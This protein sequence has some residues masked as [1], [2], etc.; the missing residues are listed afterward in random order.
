MATM[1]AHGLTDPDDELRLQD[2]VASGRRVWTLVR[3]RHQHLYLPVLV[4]AALGVLAGVVITPQYTAVMRLMP[5]RS[6]TD[7][8]ALLGMAG[9]GGMRLAADADAGAVRGELF[10]EVVASL[11]YQM[12]LAT[13]PLRFGIGDS[14][15]TFAAWIGA[16]PQT[17]T[18][19]GELLLDAATRTMA[20]AIAE[21]LQVTVDRKTGVLTLAATMPNPYAAADLV[22]GAASQLQQRVVALETRSAEAQLRFVEAQHREAAERHRSARI[23]L[24]A[25]RDQNRLL[26]SAAA[27][28]EADRLGRE[29]ELAFESYSLL[30]RELTQA[31]IRVAQDTPVF[32]VLEQAAVPLTPTT[33]NWMLLIAVS[34]VVGLVAGVLRLVWPEGEVPPPQLPP[35]PA[36]D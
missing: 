16:V 24:R 17:D 31:R 23:A 25:F 9:L 32:G 3:R 29:V 21:R 4:A 22:R 34:L 15:R 14:T 20:R 36:S 2:V 5:H 6:G 35:H 26:M 13:V 1:T 10:P 8:S 7:A 19:D 28:L 33:P 11:D 30:T 12:A 18:A 27:Q